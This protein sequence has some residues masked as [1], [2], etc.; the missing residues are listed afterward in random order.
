DLIDQSDV[1]SMKATP[2]FPSPLWGGV[3]GGGTSLHRNVIRAALALCTIIL[4]PVPTFADPTG[5]ATT[6]S[7]L[8]PKDMARVEAITK[9]TGDFSKAEQFELM[10]GGA[11]TSKKRV[12]ADAFSH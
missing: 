12:N 1:R 8:T 9:P 2:R 10:Q 11:G 5:L 6:R 4:A 7:D 3:R